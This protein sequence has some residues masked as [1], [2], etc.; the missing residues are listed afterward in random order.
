M[1]DSVIK[2]RTPYIAYLRLLL[3]RHGNL[4]S[5]FE[6]NA[7]PAL[8]L[9]WHARIPPTFVLIDYFPSEAVAFVQVH[10]DDQVFVTLTPIAV[11][12]LTIFSYQQ[13]RTK[14]QRL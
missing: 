9:E 1:F 7:W 10:L 2:V 14:H 3:A 13:G 4:H 5:Y 6:T 8:A 11:Y 12:A